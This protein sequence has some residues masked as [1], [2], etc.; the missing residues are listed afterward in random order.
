MEAAVPGESSALR[1]AICRELLDHAKRQKIQ[2]GSIFHTWDGASMRRSNVAISIRQLCVAV[3]V[4]EEKGSPRCL[5]KLYQP[6]REGI[7]RGY[8]WIRP[9]IGSKRKSSSL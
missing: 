4:P 9:R 5:R 1:R 7:E 8:W 2:R 6:T 3:G